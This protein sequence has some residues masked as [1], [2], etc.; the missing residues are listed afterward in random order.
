MDYTPV[1]IEDEKMI[2]PNLCYTMKDSDIL[3]EYLSLMLLIASWTDVAKRKLLS[4]TTEKCELN[5]GYC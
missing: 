3:T 1:H 2:I 5:S 4:T